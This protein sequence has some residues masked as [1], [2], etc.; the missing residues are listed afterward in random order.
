MQ[1]DSQFNWIIKV[2]LVVGYKKV[3][4][5]YYNYMEIKL[6]EQFYGLKRD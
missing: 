6:C 3:H 1:M 2:L 5:R 4:Y